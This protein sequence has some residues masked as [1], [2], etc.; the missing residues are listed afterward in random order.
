MEMTM[1]TKLTINLRDGIL[2]VDGSEEF[3][4]SIYDD[5]KGEVA[6]RLPLTTG[7]PR[8]I[9]AAAF[10]APEPE[11]EIPK[12][13]TKK[14]RAKRAATTG[15]GQKARAGKYKPTFDPNLNLKR[16]P[17]F[18]DRMKPENAA[19]KI[20]I[21]AVF[22]KEELKMHFCTA[23]HIYTCFFTVKDRTKIPEAF[24][25]AF[26]DTQSRTP[27]VQVTSMQEISVTIPGSNRFEEM[28]KRK[29][30]A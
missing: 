26:R 16:L 20:L 17:E 13:K 22:L 24:E 25:Q 7:A 30:A 11:A 27:F 18:Y 5:F 21:F 12:D 28:K 14:P 1:N 19:E 2:D 4:R 23:D 9:E 8:Q 29:A 6:K 3:V 10:A 15:E